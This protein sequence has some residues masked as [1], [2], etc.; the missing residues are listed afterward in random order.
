MTLASG[1]V[2]S[3]GLLDGGAGTDT[4]VMNAADAELVKPSF[5]NKI[6]NF[7][8]L[9]LT[10][11]INNVV[12]LASLDDISYVSTAGNALLTL[13]NMANAGTLEIT[14]DTTAVTVVMTDATGVADSFNVALASAATIAAGTVTV[15]GVETI[16]ITSNDTDAL[17][18]TGN[19]LL[20]VV[21]AAAKTIT[22]SGNAGLDL[23]SANTTVTSVDASAMKAAF[24]Y[25]TATTAQTVTGGSGDDLLI[26][27]TGTAV[28][29]TLIGGA[30][31]DTLVTNGGLTQLTGGLGADTFV[32]Q[33]AGLNVGIYS[34]ITDA[35]AGDTITFTTTPAAESFNTTKLVIGG[36]SSLQD[37]ANLACDSTTAETSGVISWFQFQGNTFIVEDISNN[38]DYVNGTDLIVQLTGL[39]DLSHSSINTDFASLLI[40]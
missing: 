34:T 4:L 31:D 16:A 26:A 37:Y 19:N 23:T 12:D 28:A 20:T 17:A 38:A 11:G 7:E 8:K 24:I 29:Q 22:V 36:A 35:N 5:Q 25:T 39:V 13:G 40:A 10:D 32:I 15:A 6:S 21:A 9:R 14:G 18:N 3:T 33:T 1:T 27:N 2:S 30:G